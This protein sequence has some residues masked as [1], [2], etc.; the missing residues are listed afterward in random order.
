MTQRSTPHPDSE[1]TTSPEWSD[2]ILGPG[3]Q[4]TTIP[5]GPDPD[6]ETDVV[7]TVVR[8]RPP[9]ETTRFHERPALLLVSGMTDYFF[10]TD[11][12][13]YFH[14]QGYAVYA[15][16]LRKTG[17][18]FRPGQTWHYTT[19]LSQYFV[20]LNAALDVVTAAHATMTPVAHS[21]GGLI[22][23]LWLDDLRR[24][25][26][27]R[28][29]LIDCLVLNSP[30]LDLMYP[31]ALVRISTPVINILGRTAPRLALPNDNLG[32]YGSSIH[33][34]AHGE[35]D[36][37]TT[38]KPITGHRKYFGWL[39]AIIAGQRRVHGDSVDVGVDVLTLCSARSWHSRSYSAAT[40]T[41]DAV[42][43]VDQIRTWAP[44]L[45]GDPARVTIRPI[46]GARHDVFLSLKHARFAAYETMNSW[47][48]R[49]RRREE[50]PGEQR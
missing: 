6:N 23:A 9:T 50:T 16:D 19:E 24:T 49:H 44:H 10:H 15:V 8:Y 47:L 40:D 41:A 29:R 13:E 34:S 17:R 37:N 12:A 1:R 22:A 30:W 7:T 45:N 2:D 25:D 48:G 27:G 42:L 39:R 36:F 33:I 46:D 3:Y 38:F 18:S 21:T 35:W 5:L 20:D 14:A 43:D 11:F 28:H 31:R 32:I 4:S 26:P